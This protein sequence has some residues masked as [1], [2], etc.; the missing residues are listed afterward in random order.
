M[1]SP[2]SLAGRRA[3]VTGGANGIGAA[4]CRG[5]AQAGA[6]IFFTYRNDESAA[7]AVTDDIVGFGGKVDCA[8]I[9]ASS[10]SA[11]TDLL[12]QSSQHFGVADILVNNV[13]MTSRTVFPDISSHEYDEVM[14][15][16]LRLPF[17]LTQ[18][19]AIEMKAS[20][21][22]G[23]IINVSSISATKANS[24]IAHYE[25]SK[26]ALNMLTRSAAYELGPYGI[27]V[28]SVSPG[29]TSTK[30]NRGQWRDDPAVW[31]ER[32]KNIP[33]GRTGVPEDFAGVAV[34]LASGASSWM[35]GANIVIDGGASVL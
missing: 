4:M 10:P 13:G 20:E 6:D 31:D 35:T 33:L 15:V 17:L 9:E 26:A 29:L 2:F 12:E 1:T 14:A 8:Q 32:S 21:I 24:R 27:R 16:N 18:V 23:S 25:S 7:A 22:R 5:L 11:A 19:L 3:I 30:F 34:F 28:N